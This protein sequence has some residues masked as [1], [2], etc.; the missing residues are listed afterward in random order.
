MQILITTTAAQWLHAKHPE[1]MSISANDMN[2]LAKPQF[3]LEAVGC[4]G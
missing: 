2:S 1:V 4:I 3:D